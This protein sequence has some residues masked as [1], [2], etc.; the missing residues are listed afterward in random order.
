MFLIDKN[1]DKYY[2]EP[3]GFNIKLSTVAEILESS[4]AILLAFMVSIF[5][6]WHQSRVNFC[7][8]YVRFM[9]DISELLHASLFLFS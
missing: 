3:E 9:D 2:Q 5:V 8:F 1:S 7:K 4:G 6:V